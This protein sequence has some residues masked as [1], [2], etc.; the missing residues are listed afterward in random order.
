MQ[1]VGINTLTLIDFPKHTACIIFTAGCNFR[2]GFC[3]NAD[4][5]L[6]EKLQKYQN[7]L[8]PEEAFFNFLKTR[9][10]LLDGVVISGGEPTLQPDLIPFMQKIRAQ[11]FLVKLDTNG[12]NPEVLE[13]IFAEKLIDFIAMDLKTAPE[14][15]SE[16]VG[17]SVD[18]KQIEKSRDLILQSGIDYEFRTT[19]IKEIHTPEVLAK[20][21]EFLQGAQKYALQNFEKKT[22]LNPD[23]LQYSP[24]SPTEFSNVTNIFKNKIKKVILR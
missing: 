24:F 21:A 16:I 13:K 20:M 18:L 11:N 10:G 15:Y 6:P 1:I 9:K 14:K 19:L 17:V 4:F 23:F 8:I 5:V 7:N 12:S 22:I 2:C 3:Y